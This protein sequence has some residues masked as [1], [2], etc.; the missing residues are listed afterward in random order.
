MKDFTELYYPSK[1]CLCPTLC[2]C[3][4]FWQIICFRQQL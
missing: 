3:G 4:N 2:F 1:Q